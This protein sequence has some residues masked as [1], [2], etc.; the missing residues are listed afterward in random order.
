[1]AD[2]FIGVPDCSFPAELGAQAHGPCL[3]TLINR[4][5]RDARWLHEIKL[6]GYRLIAYLA[7]TKVVFTIH[8]VLDHLNAERGRQEPTEDR[9]PRGPVPGRDAQRPQDYFGRL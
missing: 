4:A 9:H 2:G 3:A 5:P 8:L 1:M 6:D 7:R